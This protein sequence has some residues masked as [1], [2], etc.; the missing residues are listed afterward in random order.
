LRSTSRL[1]Q[2]LRNLVGNAMKFTQRGQVVVQVSARYDDGDDV[3]LHFAVSDTGVGIPQD[4][5]ANIFE[6][7][8]QGDGSTSREYGGTGLGLSICSR[9]IRLLGGAVTVESEVGKGSTFRFWIRARRVQAVKSPASEPAEADQPVRPLRILLAED[10]QINQQVAMALLTRRGHQVEVV[11]NGR[12]ALERSAVEQ[13]DAILMDVQMPE[14]DGWEATRRIRAREEGTG[15]H[16][17]IIALT[18]HA[19]MEALGQ[20]LEA[21]M[22]SFLIKPFE[23]AALYAAIEE[24]LPELMSKNF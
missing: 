18:A 23:P 14:M 6:P 1:R 13:F 15:V 20:C 7:F 10:N 9:L 11:G 5:L 8:R 2:V 22:D 4:Q 17:P 24:A 21:G 19:M 3:E 16:V 12:L